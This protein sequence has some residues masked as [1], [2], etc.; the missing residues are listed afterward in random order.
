MVPLGIIAFLFGVFLVLYV[1]MCVYP[2]K[3]GFNVCPKGCTKPT[4]I[5]GN[6]NETVEFQ[7]QT[8]KVCPW[9]CPHITEGGCYYDN[10][11]EDCEP[12]VA[13]IQNTNNT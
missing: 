7:G 1:R 8:L 11:C 6:C 5:Y 4:S 13:F 9:E 12:K 2:R 3:E 10:D